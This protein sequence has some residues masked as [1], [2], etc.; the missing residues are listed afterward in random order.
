MS[1]FFV[2]ILLI[3][4]FCGN[5]VVTSILV[6]RNSITKKVVKELKSSVQNIINELDTHTALAHD[7]SQELKLLL[8]VSEKS[9]GSS[10][11]THTRT[12][13]AA[14]SALRTKGKNT[15]SS[16]WENDIVSFINLMIDKGESDEH[17]VRTLDISFEE[18]NLVKLQR[19]R[20]SKQKKKRM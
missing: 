10:K 11:S 6:A 15:V 16:H 18:L 14:A 17:I 19:L 5:I 13:D 1:V 12:V 3:L 8:K 20:S 9:I 4:F 7:V 2:L